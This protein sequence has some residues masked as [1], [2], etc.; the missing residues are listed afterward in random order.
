MDTLTITI[1]DMAAA[2]GI[3]RR[4]VRKQAEKEKWPGEEGANNAKFFYMSF[5]P[6]NIKIAITAFQQKQQ[7]LVPA[8][9]P[10][11]YTP[12][13]P[14]PGSRSLPS[15]AR[16]DKGMAK[17]DLLRLYT[18]H[19][20]KLQHGGKVRARKEFMR[21]YNTGLAYPEIF[22]LVGKVSWKTIEGWKR[23]VKKTGETFS[24]C[25]CRGFC[26]RGK[27][28]ITDDE[29][30]IL[31]ACAL[32]SNQLLIPEVIKS[33]RDIMNVKGICNFLSDSTYTRYLNGWK[34]RN[35]HI[36]TFQ[37]E[38]KNARNDKFLKF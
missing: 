22:N 34:S 23:V 10:S 16:L 2:L 9:H 12:A 25:D 19:I 31:I 18:Q 5:L 28:K 21:A 33:A 29:K 6:E 3:S 27:S 38:G 1:K 24:L 36:W 14:D 4:A 30:N 11:P 37:R 8:T 20:S 35:Y 32:H 7:A 17:A 13:L 26:E 15:G